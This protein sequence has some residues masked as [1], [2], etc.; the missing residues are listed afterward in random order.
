MKQLEKYQ[1][2][3]SDIGPSL[4]TGKPLTWE[5]AKR[6]SLAIDICIRYSLLEDERPE[7]KAI[8]KI[9]GEALIEKED[10]GALVIPIRLEVK[11][12][13]NALADTSSDINVLPYHVYKELGREEVTDVKRGITMLNHSK[14]EPIGLSKDVL[15][16]V[17]I[18]TIIAKFLIL[19]MSI[20]RDTPIFVERGCL[21]T[22]GIILNTIERITST[23]NGI[24]H[25]KFHAAKTSL[26]TAKSDSDDEEEYAIQRK[27]VGSPIYGPKPVEYL[28]C[29]DPMDRSLALQ[30][31]L[32]L[33]RKVCVWKKVV[34]FL[35][36]LPVPLQHVDWKPDYTGCFN[37]KEEGDGKWHA[38]IRLI[39]PYGNIY[40]Q[41]LVTKK[42]SRRL[43]KY[44]KLS[45]IMS[46]NWF[47]E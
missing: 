8:I 44:Y 29:N 25:Q 15:C 10:P 38:E 12:N 45:D 35:T 30:A 17:G 37:K 20:D 24:C 26:D 3:Y 28:S 9:K 16:Q 36:S 4:S 33:F 34:S 41:G 40:D 7:E 46:P 31:V 6:E 43:S 39:D 1:L 21:Y 11:I 47:Q 5:E 23:F 42:T 32:N 22:R 14:V 13:L 2:I 27:K 18:T 19:D